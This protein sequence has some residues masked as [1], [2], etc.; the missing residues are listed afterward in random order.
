[1][2]INLPHIYPISVMINMQRR[3]ASVVIS[4]SISISI[5]WMPDIHPFRLA[6]TP[7]RRRRG[8]RGRRRQIY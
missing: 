7:E 1:M 2:I 6:D 8:R 4:I 5:D 3:S